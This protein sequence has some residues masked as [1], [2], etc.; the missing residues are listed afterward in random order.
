MVAV[1]L[2][3][4]KGHGQDDP[5]PKQ[6]SPIV[7]VLEHRDLDVLVVENSWIRASAVHGA[8]HMRE[9]LGWW[10]AG[11]VDLQVI[12]CVLGQHLRK[13]IEVEAADDLPRDSV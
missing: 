5:I 11:R 4:V 1:A 2:R 3:V 6:H 12:R 8:E 13:V 10:F 9:R 7:E